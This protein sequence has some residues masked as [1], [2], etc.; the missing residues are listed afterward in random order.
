[1]DGLGFSIVKS[2]SP[3]QSLLSITRLSAIFIWFRGPQAP[4]HT[5]GA[6]PVATRVVGDGLITA[7][8]ASIAMPAQGGSA[9]TLNGTKGFELLKAK[10]RSIPI[11]KAIA[12]RA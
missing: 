8:R 4:H 11:Q 6:V 3:L 1:L 7:T 5:L 12:L 9:A 2:I 10:A